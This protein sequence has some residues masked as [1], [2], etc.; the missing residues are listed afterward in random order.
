VRLSANVERLLNLP[1]GA[2][3]PVPK[4]QSAL[5]RLRFHQPMPAPADRKRFV[6]MVNAAFTRRRKTIENALLA[7]RPGNRGGIAAALVLAGIDGRRR[8]ETLEIEELVRLS[9][10]FESLPAAS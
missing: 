10:A 2:F 8:P 4:V 6:A 5:V 1:P 3:R 7:F 9:D